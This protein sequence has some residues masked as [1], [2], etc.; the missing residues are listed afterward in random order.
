[1]EPVLFT[2][3]KLMVER[4]HPD[5]SPSFFPEQYKG[6]FNLEGR[7]TEVK[8]DVQKNIVMIYSSIPG[9]FVT[10]K[11]QIKR[12]VKF[13]ARV[14]ELLYF[15]SLEYNFETGTVR[16]KTSQ[17]FQGVA[18]PENSIRFLL[19]QHVENF[20]K[21]AEGLQDLVR[22]PQADPMSIANTKFPPTT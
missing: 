10:G 5:S 17:I 16:Y 21:L 14:N 2:T 11:D 1:M 4:M 13:M 22:N 3:T 15:G 6:E 19:E 12:L 20:P 18:S 9:L 8:V 7:H